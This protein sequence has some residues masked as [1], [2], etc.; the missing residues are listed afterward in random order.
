MKYKSPFLLLMAFLLMSSQAFA[1]GS[2]GSGGGGSSCAEPQFTDERP[3]TD[4]AIQKLERFEIDASQ[5][6]DLKTLELEIDGVRQQPTLTPLRSGDTHIDVQLKEPR[7]TASRVRI[8]VRAKSLDG[9][10]AFKPLYF[11]IQP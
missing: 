4:G 3:K 5:N 8:T 6:T 7:T 1:Y 11:E 2:S 9:C 10:E